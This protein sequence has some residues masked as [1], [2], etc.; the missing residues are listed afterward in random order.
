[1]FRHI[2]PPTYFNPHSHVGSDLTRTQTE[3]Q[4]A[5]FN[6][7]SHVGSDV[8]LGITCDL[9][10]ISIHTPTWGVTSCLTE[11]FSQK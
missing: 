9:I 8:D 6:P 11:L 4:T 3:Q 1:M 10:C 5:N 7:H 2:A